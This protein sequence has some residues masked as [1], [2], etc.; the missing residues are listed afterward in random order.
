MGFDC[1]MYFSPAMDPSR[2]TTTNI[3][4]SMAMAGN[5]LNGVYPVGFSAPVRADARRVVILLTDGAANAGYYD[6]GQ[7]ICPAYTFTRS[8]FC[9]D[10]DPRPTRTD[11][12]NARHVKTDVFLYDA[13]DY[14][15]DMI[16]FVTTDQ[17]TLIFSIGLGALAGP[18]TDGE[19]LL[20]YAADKSAGTYYFA[21]SSSQLAG[22]V[23]N[24]TASLSR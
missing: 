17:N 14:A 24:I 6:N 19:V 18:G 8:P 3:G 16:D 15:R 4:G 10:Q 23:N 5:A 22:I 2:C 1:P 20:E 21:P 12:F 9:R 11:S 7:P 13:D